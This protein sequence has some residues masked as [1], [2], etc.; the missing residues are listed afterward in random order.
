[1][2]GIRCWEEIEEGEYSCNL[3]LVVF[4]TAEKAEAYINKHQ[5]NRVSDCTI[6]KLTC[7]PE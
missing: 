5:A 2:F 6:V 7:D 1:M 3:L 4:T